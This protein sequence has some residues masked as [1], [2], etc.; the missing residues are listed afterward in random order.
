MTDKPWEHEPDHH[1]F[2]SHGYVCEARRYE[3][4]GN[5]CGYIYIPATHPLHG[6]DYND[7][8]LTVHGGL[9]FSHTDD[10]STKFGFDCGHYMDLVPSRIAQYKAMGIDTTMDE[11]RGTYKTLD[12]VINELENLAQQLKEKENAN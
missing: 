4:M 3:H 12:Y 2:E 6:V 5:W 10:G 7:A 1:L 11:E 8:E 9:T